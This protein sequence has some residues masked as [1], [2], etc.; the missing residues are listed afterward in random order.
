M[1]ERELGLDRKRRSE[2]G[3]QGVGAVRLGH[4]EHLRESALVRC[5]MVMPVAALFFP[6]MAAIEIE[7]IH[8]PLP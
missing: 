2:R 5:K 4:C 6:F 7:Q 1:D 8:A 3:R